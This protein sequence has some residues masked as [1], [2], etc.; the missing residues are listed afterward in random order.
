[1]NFKSIF[2]GVA[3]PLNINRLLSYYDTV[4]IIA[5]FLLIQRIIKIGKEI[6]K[7]W[8]IAGDRA[9]TETKQIELRGGTQTGVAGPLNIIGF[10]WFF[11]STFL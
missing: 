8:A 10:G 1:M 6:T 11:F 9:I 2:G 3:E 7:L 5:Q 4:L